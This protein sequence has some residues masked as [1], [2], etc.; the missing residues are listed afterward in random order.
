M[1]RGRSLRREPAH[2][3]EAAENGAAAREKKEKERESIMTTLGIV[4]DD[5]TG[6]KIGRAHV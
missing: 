6:A 1:P 3:D 2:C 5:V 4:A